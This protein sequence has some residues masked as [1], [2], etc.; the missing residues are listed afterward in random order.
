MGEQGHDWVVV[1]RVEGAYGIKGWVRVRSYTHP[2]ANILD[3]QPWRL[4]LAQGAR[5]YE[6][7]DMR[8][9][10]KGFVAQLAGVDNRDAAVAL[11]GTDIEVLRDCLAP[12]GEG[13]YFWN[14]LLGLE[15]RTVSGQSLGQVARMMETG[16]NDVMVV[17]GERRRLIPFVQ[18][19]VVRAVDLEAGVIRVDWDPDF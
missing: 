12:A 18:G 1:G 13:E 5:E 17:T 7:L 11:A 19:S 4:R 9:H 16:A 10:G 8:P 6:R 3:Y 14:D 2:P 15:V